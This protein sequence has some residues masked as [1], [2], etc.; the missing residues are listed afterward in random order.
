MPRER[1]VEYL[2]AL[3][4]DGMEKFTAAPSEEQ[5][6]VTQFDRKGRTG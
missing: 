1:L 3:V 5:P 6:N 4:W 2:T